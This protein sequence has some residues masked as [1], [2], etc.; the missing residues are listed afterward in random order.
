MLNGRER[1]KIITLYILYP[2]VLIASKKN[3]NSEAYNQVNEIRDWNTYIFELDLWK[4]DGGLV[5]QQKD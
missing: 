4:M 1:W 2:D 3:P 5:E